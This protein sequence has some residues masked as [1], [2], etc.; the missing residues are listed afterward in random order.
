MLSIQP[1]K[2]K[3]IEKRSDKY[4]KRHRE[5]KDNWRALSIPKLRYLLL[6]PIR[7]DASPTCRM[8]KVAVPYIC[9]YNNY[10]DY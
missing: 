4:I 7:G 5:D 3:M 6:I 1:T 8:Q 9:L 2:E 10:W